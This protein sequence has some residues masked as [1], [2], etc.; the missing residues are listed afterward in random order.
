MYIFSQMIALLCATYSLHALPALNQCTTTPANSQHYDFQ[1]KYHFITHCYDF[2]YIIIII[3]LSP[4]NT[5]RHSI[6]LYGECPSFAQQC[7][8]VRKCHKHLALTVLPLAIHWRAGRRCLL[9]SH[10]CAPQLHVTIHFISLPL[11]RH[12]SEHLMKTKY[13]QAYTI[14][15]T[16]INGYTCI[17]TPF[18]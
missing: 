8:C 15:H 16:C 6:L 2:F 7:L 3:F 13:T 9:S 12:R 10:M 1:F 4:L 17:H 11:R 5:R 18:A 14:V